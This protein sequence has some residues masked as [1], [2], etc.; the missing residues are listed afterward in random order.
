MNEL[1]PSVLARADKLLATDSKVYGE[2]YWNSPL[3]RKVDRR[4]A[5]LFA[6]PAVVVTLAAGAWMWLHDRQPPFIEL[7]RIHPK[8]GVI[9]QR[10]VRTMY[11]GAD[12]DLERVANGQSLRVLK[13]SGDPRIISGG[14]FLRKTSLDEVIQVF[15][16]LDGRY[17]FVGAR[18]LSQGDL[19]DEIYPYQDKEPFKKYLEN[20]RAGY[21]YGGTSLVTLLGREHLTWE[22]RLQLENLLAAKDSQRADERIA[23]ATLLVPFRRTGK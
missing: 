9:F 5:R 20:L 14:A 15:D 22:Q 8:Y 13:L 21:P 18:P 3:K 17:S 11:P 12:R 4:L 2:A 1:E 19:D 7:K 10:K 23:F 6:S 16:V